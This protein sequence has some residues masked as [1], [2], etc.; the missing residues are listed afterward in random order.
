MVLER[1]GAEWGWLGSRR[2]AGSDAAGYDKR[3]KNDYASDFQPVDRRRHLHD[4]GRRG[5]GSARSGAD[6]A[7]M[8]I[9]RTGVQ[10]NAA[11]QLCGKEDAPEEQSQGKKPLG[12]LRHV[13]EFAHLMSSLY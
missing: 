3:N 5:D 11:M 4:Q 1:W 2:R 9:E 10:I 12:F 7:D 6:R 13:P 8:R